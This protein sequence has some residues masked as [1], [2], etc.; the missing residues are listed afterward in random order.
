MKARTL[1]FISIPT[2]FVCIQI[3]YLSFFVANSK[4][5]KVESMQ[6]WGSYCFGTAAVMS[7]SYKDYLRCCNDTN[8]PKCRWSHYLVTLDENVDNHWKWIASS[9]FL[10]CKSSTYI[11]LS[12][13]IFHTLT[14]PRYN[15]TNRTSIAP[16]TQCVTS[17]CISVLHSK[18]H[19]PYSIAGK[20]VRIVALST[21][22]KIRCKIGFHFQDGRKVDL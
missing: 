19:C 18:L 22:G 15:I 5:I 12:S 21:I 6:N 10:S 16:Y 2:N 7:Y 4:E 13:F 17:V 11:P 20:L 8:S 3:L 14:D 1:T 9:F